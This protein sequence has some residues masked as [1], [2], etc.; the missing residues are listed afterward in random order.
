MQPPRPI[1]PPSPTPPRHC[2]SPASIRTQTLVV[3][4]ALPLSYGP[5][6]DY[7]KIRCN[8]DYRIVIPAKFSRSMGEYLGQIT[9]RY[10]FAEREGELGLGLG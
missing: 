9:K 7:Y 2:P 1:L 6:V 3:A 4:L 8:N 10:T 5:Q